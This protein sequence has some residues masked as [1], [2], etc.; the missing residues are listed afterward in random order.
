MS[1]RYLGLV[2]LGFI[3]AS[4]SAT[5]ADSQLKVV[6][7]RAIPA[8][9]SITVYQKNEE[10]RK[11]VCEVSKFDK[12]CILPNEGPFEVLVKPKGGIP[13]K[14]AE[15]LTV[16]SGQIHELKLGELIGS[17][18]VF[19]DNFPRADKIVLTDERDPGPGEKGHVAVQV[20][21]E[22]RIDMAAP[23]G[24]YAVWAVPANGAKAQRI[25]ERVRVMAG[26]SVR[27]G[28]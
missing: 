11:S 25:V 23:P 24:F 4:V 13:I 12:P 28:D 14:V 1:A 20:A 5:D 26:K 16:K 6:I 18:E 21:T 15:N 27:V 19:G 9:E 22:Y 3:G 7:S 10:M 8:I 17:V 2:I